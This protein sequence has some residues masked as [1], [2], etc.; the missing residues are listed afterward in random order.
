MALADLA[1]IEAEM[2]AANDTFHEDVAGS[3][4]LLQSFAL[5]RERF[6]RAKRANRYFAVTA[7]PHLSGG[8]SSSDITA[9]AQSG[10]VSSDKPFVDSLTAVTTSGTAASQP[11]GPETQSIATGE[12]TMNLNVATAVSIDAQGADAGC[13]VAAIDV[14]PEEGAQTQTEAD[15]DAGMD[16][17]LNFNFDYKT[18]LSA[19]YPMMYVIIIIINYCLIVNETI[20]FPWL[21][22]TE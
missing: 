9:G 13:R 4:A 10:A 6:A 8:G 18:L 5:R 3:I 20:L 16:D 21:L 15:A 1:E 14:R 22:I 7:P 2:A 11:D 17:T 12:S 19:R